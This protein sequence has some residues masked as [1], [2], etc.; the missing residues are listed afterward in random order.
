MKGI[1]DDRNDKQ[2]NSTMAYYITKHDNA[3]HKFMQI[4]INKN[5]KNIFYKI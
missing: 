4:F 3:P 1:Q 2:L 5:T